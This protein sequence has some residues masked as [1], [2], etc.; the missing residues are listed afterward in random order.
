[1]GFP[2]IGAGD[3]HTASTLFVKADTAQHPQPAHHSNS[4]PKQPKTSIH[5]FRTKKSAILPIYQN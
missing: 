2:D 1:M 3:M 4:A 5:T